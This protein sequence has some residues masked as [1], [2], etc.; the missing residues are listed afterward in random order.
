MEPGQRP[1]SEKCKMESKRWGQSP[2]GSSNGDCPFLVPENQP[3]ICML[4]RISS[5][6]FSY[7]T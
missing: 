1:R 6:R 4:L 7:S 3:V 5:I 2:L